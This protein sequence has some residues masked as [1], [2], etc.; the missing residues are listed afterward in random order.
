MAA[1]LPVTPRL[2]F[3]QETIHG[4]I[5]PANIILDADLNPKIYDFG[6][7]RLYHKQ[8][9]EGTMSYTAP[10]VEDRSLEASAD[11]YSF[12]VVMLILVS[13]RKNQD[14]EVRW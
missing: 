10:E 14:P 5:K 12:G 4:D 11:V 9:S 3:K 7:V 8:K 6:F 13:G 1:T 2:P